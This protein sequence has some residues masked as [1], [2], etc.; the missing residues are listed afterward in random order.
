MLPKVCEALVLV[1]QCIVTII[2]A[3]QG[4]QVSPDSEVGSVDNLQDYF[5]NINNP[6]SIGLVENLI[7]E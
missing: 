6:D 1:T 7:G 2:L 4:A 5:N 3:S